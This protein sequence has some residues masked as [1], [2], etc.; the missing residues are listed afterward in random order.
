MDAKQA[1][2]GYLLTFD[3]RKEG[4]RENKAEWVDIGDKKIFDV[5]V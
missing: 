2:S 1:A 4:N 5:M 3:L